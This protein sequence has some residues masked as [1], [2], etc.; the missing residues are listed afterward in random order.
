MCNPWVRRLVIDNP[1]PCFKHAV[2]LTDRLTHLTLTGINT[3]RSY[4]LRE[5]N[6]R[7]PVLRYLKCNLLPEDRRE[8]MSV[9]ARPVVFLKLEELTTTCYFHVTRSKD[10]RTVLLLQKAV[11]GGRFPSL[12]T[13]RLL[14]TEAQKDSNISDDTDA[15]GQTC[16]DNNIHLILDPSPDLLPNNPNDPDPE[17]TMGRY[18]SDNPAYFCKHFNDDDNLLKPARTQ[19]G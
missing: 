2:A 18:Y 16:V 15:L 10:W 9:S 8:L 1:T 7:H 19:R 12:Q 17:W 4:R 6:T 13:L 11:K 3:A 5:I 14:D